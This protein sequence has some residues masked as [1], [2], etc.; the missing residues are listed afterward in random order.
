MP[1]SPTS[2]NK[3][4]MRAVIYA[5]VSTHDQ[6]TIPMQVKKCQEYAKARNWIVSHVMKD[7]ASG[8]ETEAPKRRYPEARKKKRN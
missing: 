6:N 2:F 5:R 8:A 4:I 7:I 1:T 3:E